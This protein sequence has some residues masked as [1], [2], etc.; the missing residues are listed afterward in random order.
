MAGLSDLLR[1]SQLLR[2]AILAK[3]PRNCTLLSQQL[4]YGKFKFIYRERVGKSEYTL[5]RERQCTDE[6]GRRSPNLRAIGE[7]NSFWNNVSTFFCRA[8]QDMPSRHTYST[9][10]IDFMLGSLGIGAALPLT[11]LPGSRVHLQN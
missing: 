4:P 11:V 3:S 1:L 9:K 10:K 6:G 8:L 7:L 2:E 5:G